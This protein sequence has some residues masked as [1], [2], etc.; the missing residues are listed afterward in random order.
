MPL[1]NTAARADGLSWPDVFSVNTVTTASRRPELDSTQTWR[2]YPSSDNQLN[3]HLSWCV[4]MQHTLHTSRACVCLKVFNKLQHNG[5]RRALLRTWCA[6]ALDGREAILNYLA[7]LPRG[8][9]FC[10]TVWHWAA[11]GPGHYTGLGRRVTS[12]YKP[13]VTRLCS[14]MDLSS[15]TL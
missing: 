9:P 3:F 4:I 12:I 11:D 5:A 10:S 15:I 8:L 7:R 2:R 13:A 6:R 14:L 1:S